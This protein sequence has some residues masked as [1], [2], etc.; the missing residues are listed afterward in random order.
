MGDR[1][2]DE[3]MDERQL[4]RSESLDHELIEP[5]S[6]AG[7]SIALVL[8]R[9]VPRFRSPIMEH[10]PVRPVS[11]DRERPELTVP[12]ARDVIRPM[13]W[14]ML[15]AIPVLLLVGWQAALIVGVAAALIRGV[16]GMVARSNLSFADGFIGFRGET[17]WPRGVQEEDEV[18]WN[19][20][21]AGSGHAA[22][23]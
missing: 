14:A 18:R 22:H 19:W 7:W 1:Q 4:S 17:S 2:A 3:A 10:R 15:L 23:G 20:S 5:S 21:K 6:T 12:A 8:F 9:P 16:D 13:G 11:P